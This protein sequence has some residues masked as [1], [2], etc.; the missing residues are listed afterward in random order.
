[1]M[2]S[3]GYTLQHNDP[4]ETCQVHIPVSSQSIKL[5]IKVT[6]SMG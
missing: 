1:M 3:E 6:G 5:E 2:N 4:S